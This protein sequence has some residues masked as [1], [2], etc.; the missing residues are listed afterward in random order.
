MTRRHSRFLPRI[1]PDRSLE[2][3]F[4]FTLGLDFLSI[5]L[6]GLPPA[7][8]G[9]VEDLSVAEYLGFNPGYCF[10][11]DGFLQLALPDDDDRPAFGLQLAPDFLIVLLIAG[12]FSLPEFGVGL[13]R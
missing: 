10:I 9:S 13:W 5:C 4:T 2:G 11:Q 1:L 3:V 7:F 6:L 8:Y 12:N